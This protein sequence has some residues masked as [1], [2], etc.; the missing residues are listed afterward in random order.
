MSTSAGLRF[1][2]GRWYLVGFDRDRGEARTFRVDRVDGPARASVSPC[3]SG[4]RPASTSTRPSGATR[5]SSVT[6]RTIEV[7]V[8]I[9]G[10][11][12][13][14]VVAELGEARRWSSAGRTAPS[15]YG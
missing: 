1:R 7:E 8:L 14:R 6:A 9:D 3:R 11:E 15:W 13:A 2:D 5:G 10:A 12:S 4:Y